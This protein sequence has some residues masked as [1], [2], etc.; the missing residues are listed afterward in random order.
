M[1]IPMTEIPGD[2]RPRER[3]LALGP[4]ALTDTELLAVLLR[5]G[6]V[7][8]S[9]LDVSAKL[10]AEQGGLQRLANARPE[11]LARM[12]GVGTVKAA[13]LVA[14]FHLAS[15]AREPVEP[16]SD[17]HEAGEIA[18]V[19]RPLFFGA[20]TERLVVLVA[21][22]R[23]RLRYRIVLAEGCIDQVPLPLREILNV[24]LRQ[25]GRGFALAHNHPSGDPEPSWQDK[26]SSQVL[27]DAA[28][29]LG[30]RFLDHVVL[31]GEQ[32]ASAVTGA[33]NR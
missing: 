23:D 12:A 10:L 7:G 14:A 9:A 13:S 15:R 29:T 21:D 1:S 27:M 6:K 8:A 32:W 17:L 33:T 31:A 5:N 18:A 11:E 20:R 3:L 16:A 2:Q 22:A 19:A 4:Q 24:V 26:R 30:L 25:D 28:A